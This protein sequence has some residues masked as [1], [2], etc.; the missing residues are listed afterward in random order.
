M[1]LL[2]KVPVLSSKNISQ[3]I[4]PNLQSNINGKSIP[5]FIKNFHDFRKTS[6][7]VNDVLSLS[8]IHI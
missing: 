2:S 8:L 7:I 1:I 5:F 4:K 3:S 6:E